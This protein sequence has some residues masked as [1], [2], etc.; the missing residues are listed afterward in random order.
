MTAQRDEDLKQFERIHRNLTRIEDALSRFK[1]ALV[2]IRRHIHE[3]P[4][5][6]DYIERVIAQAVGS[7]EESD[8]P[9]TTQ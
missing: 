6:E 1:H 5:S 3:E 4:I 7:T 8:D 9:S 2:E